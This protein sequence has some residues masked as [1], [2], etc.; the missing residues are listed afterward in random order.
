MPSGGDLST[1]QGWW[2]VQNLQIASHAPLGKV[3]HTQQIQSALLPGTPGENRGLVTK[4]H[5]GKKEHEPFRGKQL[6]NC[7]ILYHKF[8]S[9][10]LLPVKKF[11]FLPIF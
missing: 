2:D 1:S 11:A 3:L 9:R 4:P 6:C 5:E 7:F 8:D 10:D